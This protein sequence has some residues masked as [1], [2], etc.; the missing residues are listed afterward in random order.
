MDPIKPMDHSYQLIGGITKNHQES[1]R[2]STNLLSI[3]SRKED[4]IQR[5]NH[6][7]NDDEKRQREGQ[8]REKKTQTHKPSPPIE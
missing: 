5:H 8:K 1:P 7:Q 6:R 3:S 4:G 2:I